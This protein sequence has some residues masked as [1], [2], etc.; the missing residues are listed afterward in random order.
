MIRVISSPSSSTT[1]LVTLIFAIGRRS[2]RGTHAQAVRAYCSR[3]AP[4]SEPPVTVGPSGD[5]RPAPDRI[6]HG[7]RPAGRRRSVL[8][9]PRRRPSR[10]DRRRVALADEPD[11]AAV[12]AD[13]DWRL[14]FRCFAIRLGD[15][16]G[17]RRR[18]HRPGRRARRAWAPVPGRLP[19]TRRGRHRPRRGRHG[20][21]DP[22]AQRPHR[23]GGAPAQPSSQRALLHAAGRDRG[24]RRSTSS[25]RPV[26]AGPAARPPVSSTRSTATPASRRA[27]GCVPTPG[28]TP[29]HQSVLLAVAATTMLVTG[30]LLVHAVQLVTPDTAYAHEMDPDWPAPRASRCCATSADAP[31]ASPGGVPTWATVHQL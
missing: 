19:A 30:D 18:R 20:R 27:C 31:G 10:R 1:G 21:P 2:S 24:H 6:R 9:A 26:R 15:G 29:G 22:P 8:R 11:P 23:L 16:S 25:G 28:H 3:S 5:A 14:R 4:A 7:H 12:T 17:D 13:G